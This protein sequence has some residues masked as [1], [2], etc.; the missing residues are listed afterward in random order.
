MS[1][2]SAGEALFKQYGK[3]FQEKIFQ[4]LL[5]DHTWAAQ[6]SEVME[7]NYFDLKYLSFL[8]NKYFKYHEKYKTFPTFSL[9]VSII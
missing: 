3:P 9:L 1:E 6:M 5:T 4:G 2:T 8:S 7:P